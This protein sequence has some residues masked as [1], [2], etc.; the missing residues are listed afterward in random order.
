MPSPRSLSEVRFAA[1][2]VYSPDGTDE[3]SRRSARAVADIKNCLPALIT[4]IGERF[5]EAFRDGRFGDFLGDDVLLVPVPRSAPFK[6]KDAAWPARKI[7]DALASRKLSAGVEPLLVR[8]TAVRKSALLRKGA[9]RPGP[10]D[11]EATIRCANILAHSPPRITIVDDV[12]TRGATLLGCVRVIAARFPDC[13][14]RALAVVRT[15]SKQTITAM[16]EPVEGRIRSLNGVPRREPSE[17][18]IASRLEDARRPRDRRPGGT[19]SGVIRKGPAEV[20]PTTLH[21]TPWP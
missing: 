1:L 8:H 13:E 7:C 17:P 15:M 6:T 3:V 18:A 16:L 19:S 5:E 20:S 11:H 4:R 9:E 14:V 12:V 2:L 10:E 21:A